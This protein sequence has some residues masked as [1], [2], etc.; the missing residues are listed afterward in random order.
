M[1]DAN[2]SIAVHKSVWY[3][4]SVRYLGGITLPNKDDWASHEDKLY[5]PFDKPVIEALRR[6][7]FDIAPDGKGAIIGEGELQVQLQRL[8]NAEIATGNF[9]YLVWVMLPNN[10]SFVCLTNETALLEGVKDIC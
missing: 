2:I 6:L 4:I 5:R 1:L 7:G 8:A 3:T 9:E 10:G